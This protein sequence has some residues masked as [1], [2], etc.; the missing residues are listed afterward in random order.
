MKFFL[1]NAFFLQNFSEK[2]ASSEKV[3][4]FAPS[5]K[6]KGLILQNWDMV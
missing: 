1:K 6:N 3:C 2:F 5:N 4:I